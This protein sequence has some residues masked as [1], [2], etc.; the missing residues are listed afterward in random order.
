MKGTG[1]KGVLS[2]YLCR[3]SRWQEL[4]LVEG[5]LRQ[6]ESLLGQLRKTLE[7]YHEMRT[8]YERLLKDVDALEAEK[9]RT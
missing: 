4:A 3:C 8:K 7:G 6:K 1:L 2:R 5:E 9:V